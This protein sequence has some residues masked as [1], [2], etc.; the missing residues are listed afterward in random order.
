MLTTT[1]THTLDLDVIGPVPLTVT[2]Q[3]AGRPV[4]LLHGGAGP[5]SMTPFADRLARTT[6]TRVITPT[7]PGFAGTPRPDTLNSITGLA[8]LYTALLDDL[9]LVDVT[10]IGNSVG[11][12]I[13]A[14]IALT[15]SARIARMALL[16][17]TGIDVA[18][19][20]VADVL[21]KTLPEILQLSFHN[22]TPFLPDPTA[23]SP[24]A[25][26][27]AAANM[28]ALG[29]YTQQRPADPHLLDRLS[30]IALATLVLWGTSDRIADAD[31]GRAW[32]D[33]IPHATFQVLP[34]T[35][36]LPQLETPEQVLTAIAD[37]MTATAAWEH[38][39]TANTT[40]PP[41]NVWTILRELYTGTPL[42]DTGDDI[43]IHGPFTTGTR[44]SITPHGADFVVDC[45]ITELDDGHTY[46]YRSNF[47]GLYLTSRH[48]LT[49]LA[50]GGTQINHHSQI[51]G[52]TAPTTAP[53]LGPRITEDRAETMHHLTTAAAIYSSR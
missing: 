52:P 16:D 47:N 18:G 24:D 29:I 22:A 43:A 25:Q 26:R 45:V 32:A 30:G 21:D 51:A 31:I 38:D 4:L 15:A 36:H 19:H 8:T 27:V 50:S 3:G 13:A 42:T 53:Q 11:G 37:F 6:H 9:D 28:T 33:A 14:E 44:L 34:D 23:V 40:A 35:G 49:P 17:A 10:V 2:D 7:H 48:T 39:Y 41:E 5:Q 20:P 12:W 46:A 1:T